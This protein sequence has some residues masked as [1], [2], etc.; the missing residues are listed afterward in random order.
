MSKASHRGRWFLWAFFC[1]GALAGFVQPTFAQPDLR[2]AADT[3]LLREPLPGW[4]FERLEGVPSPAETRYRVYVAVPR[5]PPPTEGYPVFYLLDG[6]AALDALKAQHAALE[7]LATSPDAP[8]LVMIGYETTSRFDVVARAYD[9]TPPVPGEADLTDMPGSGRKAGG[10]E[11]F[12]DFLVHA[13]KPELQRKFHLNP[14]R[15]TL[16]G[17][18]YGGLFALHILFTHPGDF[19]HYVAVSPALWWHDGWIFREE[20][21][22]AGRAL[23]APVTLLALSGTDEMG[24]RAKTAPN[25]ADTRLRRHA[26]P[27]ESLRPLIARLNARKKLSAG[28]ILFD[29]KT[30]GEMFALGLA[31][32]LA[33][34]ATGK[35]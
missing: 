19:Q 4:R 14:S 1:A 29:D 9:Y 24:A 3:S 13:L 18:S 26:P 5:Q 23:S 22:F 27:Q 7:K 16:W 8:V 33:H 28:L 15:Q 17:H 21:A 12:R 34:Q 35:K 10:A 25:P 11:I 6:N 31:A 30:H 32:L 20:E 2:V